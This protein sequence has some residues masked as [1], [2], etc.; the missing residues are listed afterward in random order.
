[1][2][3]YILGLDLG[4]NS[5]G[6]A[7]I[8]CDETTKSTH[9]IDTNSRI[10]LAMIEADTKV[11]KNKQ[12]RDKRLSRRQVGRYK[13]RRDKLLEI[14]IAQHLLP[15]EFQQPADWVQILTKVGNLPEGG[16]KTFLSSDPFQLRADALKRNLTASEFG[17]VMMHLV[18]RR[19]Y[20]SNRDIKYLALFDYIQE[21][22]IVIQD[23][24]E[25]NEELP[26]DPE[27]IN[28]STDKKEVE[29]TGKVLGGIRILQEQMHSDETIG[30]F[31]VR[32]AQDE[33]WETPR[34]LHTISMDE[35]RT[36][37]KGKNRGKEKTTHY[38][39]HATRALYE[40]EF[41]RIWAHQADNLCGLLK[42][43]P[44]QIKILREEIKHAIFD[45]L[46]LQ[47]QKGKVGMCSIRLKK[48]RAATALLESQEYLLLQDINNLMHGEFERGRRRAHNEPA[49]ALT[50]EQRQQL[51]NALSD[52][53]QMDESG[54]LTW[55]K[56]REIL[57]LPSTTKFNLEVS[58]NKDA[59]GERIKSSKKG[60]TGNLTALAIARVIPAAW[61]EFTD[62]Q[63]K[64]LVNDLLNIHG[65]QNKNGT[66]KLEDNGK[67]TL[68]NRLRNHYRLPPQRCPWQF[69]DQQAFKLATLELP[70]GY[71]G[72]CFEV[73]TTLLHYLKIGMKYT[74]AKAHEKF[75]EK[76]ESKQITRL[77]EPP[78]IA[79]PIVQKALYETRRVMNAI[80][81]RQGGIPK[82][83][84]IEMARD[85]KASK[86][87]RAEMETRDVE[88]R[89]LN[90]KAVAAIRDWNQHHPHQTIGLEA[91]IEKIKLWI[92]QRVKPDNESTIKV[93]LWQ[94]QNHF[95][96]FSGK[97]ISFGQI[98]EGEVDIDH[99]YPR[100]I[101]GMNDYLNKVLAFKSENL[102]KGQRT[103]W[104]A[105]AGNSEKYNQI[106]IRA[107]AWYGAKDTPLKAKL[108]KIKDKSD[109]ATFREKMADFTNAQLNDTRYICVAVKNYLK[110]LGYADQEIQVSRGRATAE[111]RRLWG[112]GNILPK[113]RHE[114]ADSPEVAAEAET[115]DE[116]EEQD[117]DQKKKKKKDR[118]DHRHHAIDAVITA[119]TDGKTFADLQKRYRYYELKGSWPDAALEKP[120]LANGTTWESLRRDVKEIVMNRVVSFATNRK[121]SGGLHDEQ[122]YGLGQYFDKYIERGKKDI[123]STVTLLQTRPTIINA[124]PDGHPS[125]KLEDSG[126]WIA[127][128]QIR[129]IMQSWLAD[130]DKVEIA[131]RKKFPPPMLLNEEIKEIVLAHRCYLKR[132]ELVEALKYVDKSPGVGTWIADSRTREMLKAWRD[133]PGNCKKTKSEWK[134][135]AKEL[136]RMA[137]KQNKAARKG[138]EIKNVRLATKSTGMVQFNNKP[139]IFA[140]SSNHHVAIFKRILNGE[141]VE[142][143]GVFVGLLEAAKR[144]RKPPVVRK[145]PEELLA[146]NPTINPDEWQFEMFLC[147][148]DMVLWDRD[149]PD[150]SGNNSLNL[151]SRNH[152][153]PIYRLQKMTEGQLTFRHF[154]VTSSAD[155]DSRGVIRR[156]P[157]KLRCKKI[158]MDELGNYT[159]C[160][161]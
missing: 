81:E 36:L 10:F 97:P 59:S 108:D 129:T 125:K 128:E 110:T 19:G 52:P 92:E 78:N 123:P 154:S 115:P 43:T 9:L 131:K 156:A 56:A 86:K 5:I 25:E 49:Q 158:R 44:E 99:I 150:W 161:D 61:K 55:D 16:L 41:S 145:S 35:T 75:S 71:M 69:S 2:Q 141:I 8:G 37:T 17:R 137:P 54:R 12:R 68:F 106:C 11:P 63:R 23:T 159:I 73:I 149:D 121:V 83:I 27:N 152:H 85:M 80:I 93:K 120:M 133:E 74:E 6:W 67:V 58:S 87:H 18:K 26:E 119:L 31:V 105:W 24:V 76:P 7:T 79:N 94:E 144:I 102:F 112:L 72:H 140:T 100:S 155:T 153:L 28:P 88:R 13:E 34:R 29:E 22:N 103:P 118:G 45:Q 124:L 126:T 62:A 130:R 30:Q 20:K 14:L 77:A 117:K 91:G 107:Q 151:D 139:Q 148:N 46:P 90:E 111:I 4:T 95:C 3:S 65:K 38:N 51:M 64:A 89:K 60:I 53:S 42:Q 157:T 146:D 98:A 39:L 113:T 135:L 109:V 82:I 84:R 104:Q 114:Q 15:S 160:D 122:P 33:K 132:K 127:N 147:N 101:S 48:K 32:K 21:N 136:P 70:S 116:A 47:L 40:E 66:L 134:I 96:L 57:K 50:P 143:K 1:M 142:R 138:N